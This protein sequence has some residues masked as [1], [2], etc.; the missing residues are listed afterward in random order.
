MTIENC[1]GLLKGQW[2][3]LLNLNVNSIDRA[4]KIVETCILLHNYNI[5]YTLERELFPTEVPGLPRARVAD[6]E[7]TSSAGGYAKRE[8]IA[9]SL[10]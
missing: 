4:N 6:I 1:F 3:R 2:R 8:A 10:I 9:M 7:I 5:R